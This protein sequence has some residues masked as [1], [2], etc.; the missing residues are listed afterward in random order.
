MI[1]PLTLRRDVTSLLPYAARG[2]QLQNKGRPTAKAQ[3][4]IS[5]VLKP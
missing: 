2:L 1:P 5:S 4:Y 3:R